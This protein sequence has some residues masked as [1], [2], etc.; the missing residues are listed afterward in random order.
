M[1][2]RF[3]PVEW[4][5]KLQR[6]WEKD[7]PMG[8]LFTVLMPPPNANASLH[9]GHGMYVI[10]DIIIRYKRIQGFNAQWIPGMDHAGFET[11]FVYEKHLQKQGK[12]R[13][14]FDRETLYNNIFSFVKENSGTIYSQFKRLGFIAQWDKSVF[15]LDKHVV[16]H[17]YAT[18]AQMEKEGRIYKD[19]YIVNFCVH[20]GTSLADLE[21]AHVERQD[22][23]YYVRYHLEDGKSITVATVRPETIWLDTHLAVNPTDK[24]RKHLIGARVVNPLTQ[25]HMTIIG[26]TYADPAFGTG[27]VKLTP[28][29]DHNDFEVAKRH[30]LPIITGIGY[31]GKMTGGAYNRMK[32]KEAR[33]KIARELEEKGALEKIDPQYTHNV[34]VCYKCKRDL[35]PMVLPN[36]FLRVSE[37]KEAAARSVKNDEIQ[38]H[39][40]KYKQQLLQWYKTMHDWPISRQIVWGIRVPVWYDAAKNPTLYVVFK[41]ENETITGTLG[42]LLKKYTLADI[43]KG[44]QK[45]VAPKDAAYV[46]SDT[47]PGSEFIPETD[48]FDT[49]FSSGQWPLVTRPPEYPTD[50]IG[51]LS[52]ILTFW[53]SRMIMF[54]LY[55]R[56]TVPFRHVYLWSMV[57]DAKGQKMSKSKGNVIDPI[58]LV[59]RYGADAFRSSLLF[60]LA[61]GGKVTLSEDKVRAMRNFANKVWNMGRFI[62]T[63]HS[64]TDVPP[65]K[66]AIDSLRKKL[67]AQVKKYHA[68]MEAYQFSRA[69]NGLYDYAWHEFADR[70]IEALKD[71]VNNGSIEARTAL[72]DAFREILVMLHPFMPYV[73]DAL[74][75]MNYK[76]SI[77]S[78]NQQWHTKE[79]KHHG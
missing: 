32:V 52:D 79:T 3:N 9:A 30:N 41:A 17:V 1:D 64:E 11:Q 67:E 26:D 47:S 40:K 2:S 6:V 27:I 57:T 46:V 69:F 42:E 19:D 43:L 25:A 18:F 24:K 36:W 31:D 21:V 45:I 12:S 49:W 66:K 62:Y 50:F 54:S 76:N 20:C 38:F 34:S 75:T 78:Y 16:N 48:T 44:L 13:F 73:T 53:I 65:N 72:R 70:D 23:L 68:Q 55:V 60:G 39:P 15:T 10:D 7:K 14:D 28:G 5:E 61:Q 74:Y 51:T 58:L 59:D 56:D 33:E 22:P 35:E 4:E 29:H 71:A 8:P 63:A 77:I 37:L